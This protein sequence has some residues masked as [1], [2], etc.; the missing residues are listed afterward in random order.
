MCWFKHGSSHTHTHTPVHGGNG[1][2]FYFH[3]PFHPSLQED[4]A[5]CF[6]L[7]CRSCQDFRYGVRVDAPS[8]DLEKSDLAGKGEY[9]R[10]VGFLKQTDTLRAL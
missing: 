9:E 2:R 5:S 7:G 8:E 6:D 4:L 1:G 10:G 3:A